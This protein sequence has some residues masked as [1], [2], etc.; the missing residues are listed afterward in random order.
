MA[1]PDRDDPAASLGETQ[2]IAR[3]A[4]AGDQEL[5]H[6]LYERVTPALY[7]W[8]RMRVRP[9]PNHT[10]DVQDVLQEVWMR[11]FA[12][13]EKY[14]P[15]RSFRGWA[16]GIA[17]KVMLESYRRRLREPVHGAPQSPSQAHGMLERAKSV[18]TIS[19][20]M[21]KDEAVQRF[22]GYVE[23]LDP[24]DRLLVLYCGF[25]ESTCAEAATR[26]GLSEDAVVKRWQRLRAQMRKSGH[27]RALAIE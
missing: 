5:F 15:T 9:G 3:R 12:N 21:S 2:W 10:D 8:T 22:L 14:D 13:F 4:L 17:K 25:E 18:S 23:T 1:E 20:R 16:L 27:L 6:A 19:S 7:A 11:A 26:M 24:A